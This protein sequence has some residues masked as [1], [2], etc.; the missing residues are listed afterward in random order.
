MTRFPEL[1]E[2]TLVDKAKT[3]YTGVMLAFKSIRTKCEDLRSIEEDARVEDLRAMW[4][5]DGKLRF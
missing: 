1:E 4:S 2:T 5:Q 3:S